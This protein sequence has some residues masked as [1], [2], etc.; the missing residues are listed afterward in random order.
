MALEAEL[1]LSFRSRTKSHPTTTKYTISSV[2]PLPLLQMQNARNFADLGLRRLQ[3]VSFPLGD[4]H[5][6]E[7][8]PLKKVVEDVCSHLTH[9]KQQLLRSTT[10][11]FPSTEGIAPLRFKPPLPPY[12]V[13]EIGICDQDLSVMVYHLQAKSH[14]KTSSASMSFA[15]SALSLAGGSSLV[16][17]TIK[18]GNTLMEV[19]DQA[20]AR[21]RVS[22]IADAVGL[23]HRA[24]IHATELHDKIVA[25]M[26]AM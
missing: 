4:D 24:F 21:C 7:L 26:T 16:G 6:A 22:N 12:L 10:D 23:L 20:E 14:S 15:S 18:R 9:S 13:M 3:E 5:M 25:L 19:A 11:G 17:Y 1:R 2:N 8:R